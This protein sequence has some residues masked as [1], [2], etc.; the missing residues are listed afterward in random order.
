MTEHPSDDVQLSYAD[1]IVLCK[2]ENNDDWG[3]GFRVDH[4]GVWEKNYSKDRLLTTHEKAALSQHQGAPLITF[5]CTIGDI[6]N[7]LWDA[8]G[9]GFIDPFDL[10]D[11]V[12][13]KNAVAT[14]PTE[15]PLG[16]RER[17]TLLRIICA[18]DVMAKLPR[19]AAPS[20]E[21]QLQMLGFEGPKNSVIRSTIEAARAMQKEAE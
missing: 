8:T 6:R 4:E 11:I 7:R 15:K 1:F 12:A 10:A 16:K 3:A 13:S 9:G 5:P 14:A 21:A 18:L 19:A 2:V 17:S 20:V